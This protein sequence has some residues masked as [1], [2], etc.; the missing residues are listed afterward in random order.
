VS[1]TTFPSRLTTSSDLQIAQVVQM[2]VPSVEVQRADARRSQSINN[3][4][5]IGLAFHNYADTNGKFPAA[6][7]LGPDG[8]TPHSWRVAILPYI[9]QNDLY[10]QYK[11]DEPWDSP[12]NRKIL[13]KMPAIYRN[14]LSKSM[15][16]A[17]YYVL[18]GKDTLF[19]DHT[20]MAIAQITDGTSNTI[21]AVEAERDI[22]WTKPEDIPFDPTDQK[23]PI[24]KLGGFG[25]SDIIV[26]FAD[27]S[28]RT[29]KLTINPNI[30][31]A[32]STR[33]GGEVISS[34]A[35]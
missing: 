19:P 12:S 15:T 14:P 27:G 16:S 9:E 21:M 5:Q 3:L 29:L 30:F 4:K 6:S 22:P 35:F 26:L 34:D 18:T 8:K 20:G 28:V 1:R 11:F 24:P 23:T 25:G 2:L 10:Q 33:D 17:S 7:I 31:R 32:I 13:D